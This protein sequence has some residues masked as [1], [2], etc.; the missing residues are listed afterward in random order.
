MDGDGALAMH[1]LLTFLLS[2]MLFILSVRLLWASTS[3]SPLPL[4]LSCLPF[5]SAGVVG[6]SSETAFAFLS[7]SLRLAARTKPDGI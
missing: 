1:D 6:I 4:L 5:L 3:S 7:I 2:C